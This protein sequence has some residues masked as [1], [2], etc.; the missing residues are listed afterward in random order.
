[1]H[2]QQR[3]YNDDPYNLTTLVF[4]DIIGEPVLKFAW[5]PKKCFDGQWVWLRSVWARPCVLKSHLDGFR[6]GP[7]MQY[8]KV[9]RA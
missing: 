7:W 4:C 2:P 3:A 5:L 8:A 1:M 6:T 9:K